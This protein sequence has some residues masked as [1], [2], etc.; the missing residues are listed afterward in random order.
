LRKLRYFIIATGFYLLMI[1]SLLYSSDLKTGFEF[2]VSTVY[3]LI[4][5]LVVIFFVGNISREHMRIILF[6]FVF[7]CLAYAIYIHWSFFTAGLYTSFKPAEFYD[8]PFR[9]VVMK[10]KYRSGHPTYISMWFLFSVLFLVHFMLEARLSLVKTIGLISMIG[11]FVFSSVLLS[12]KIT[13]VAFFFSILLLIYLMLKNK[14]IILLSYSLVAV[15]FVFALLNISFLRA[16]F[17]DEFQ[18][19]ELKPPVG[20][21]T[22]S[23]NIRVGIFECSKKVFSENWLIGTGVGDFQA[24]LDKCY[25]SFDTNVYKESTYNTHNN[26]FGI[27]VTIGTIG[28]AAFIF[29][30]FFNIRE[31]IKLNNTM[32]LVFLLFVIICMLPENILSR[33]HGVVFYSLFCSLFMKMNMTNSYES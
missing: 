19:T 10:L 15:M 7:G 12:A 26:F 21:A 30:L 33:N 1:C 9:A 2:L 16:R 4:Y 20:I 28:L 22:N 24:E 31:S 17:I 13:F 8:L 23:L 3:I 5:P 18:A 29:M 25:S 27:A 6:S 11:I 14:W 32:F